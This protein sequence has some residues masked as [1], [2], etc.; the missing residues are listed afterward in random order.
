MSP[1]SGGADFSGLSF[2]EPKKTPAW[3][4]E[5]NSEMTTRKSAIPLASRVTAY[6]SREHAA[7]E[8]QVSPS[9]FDDLVA[10]GYLPKARRIG[11]ILRWRW[12]DI[13][14]AICKD[15]VAALN[16]EPYFK[17][18]SNGTATDRK[19]NAAA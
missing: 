17:G 5:L 15:D 19:R 1:F 9:T 14:A 12:Q 4:G 13:D 6:V 7:A 2:G 11:G 8:L 3:V 10:G 16:Q 18:S